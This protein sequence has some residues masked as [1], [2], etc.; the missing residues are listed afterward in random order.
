M[1]YATHLKVNK[2]YGNIK[3]V[4]EFSIFSFFITIIVVSVTRHEIQINAIL[5]RL[6]KKE[7]GKKCA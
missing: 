4:C 2:N 1:F 7:K 5:K 3:C 6:S